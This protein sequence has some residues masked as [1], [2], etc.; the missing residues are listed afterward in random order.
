[1]KALIIA[2]KPSVARDIAAALGLGSAMENDNLVISHCIGHL[3]QLTYPLEQNQAL[4]I[5]PKSFELKVIDAVKDQFKKLAALIKRN[6]IATIINAC[7]AGREGEL[8]FRLVYDLVNIEK[9]IER[10]W[11]QSM[12]P[13]AIKIAYTGRKPGIQYQ[14]LYDAARSRSEA[15]WLYGINGSRAVKSAVG[16]V[17]TPTLAMVVDRY[18]IN[19]NFKPETFYEVVADFGVD[20]GTYQGK[21]NKDN[22]DIRFRSKEKAQEVIE[23]LK[24]ANPCKIEETKESKKKL[25]PLLFHLTGLQQEANRKF[26]YSAAD[27]LAITQ[28]LYEKHKVVTYPRTDSN[29]LPSDYL[30]TASQ[31]IENLSTVIPSASTVLE[32]NWIQLDKR[33]FNDAMI[34]DHFAI[35][36]TGKIPS[37]LTEPEKNIYDL[38]VKR[39]IAIFYPAAEY[40]HTIRLTQIGQAI[41]K[42]TGNVLTKPGWLSVYGSV[43]ESEESKDQLLTPVASGEQAQLLELSVKTGKTKPPALFNEATLLKAMETAGKEIDN[44][45]L[46]LAL[47]GKGIGTP[48]T[49]AAI[50]EKL[51]Q[52]TKAEPYLK[53]VKKS[54]VPT[55]RGLKLI[56]YLRQ[57]APTIISPELTGEWE[58][59][60]GMVERGQLTR[61]NFMLEINQAVYDLVSSLPQYSSPASVS[62]SL[63]QCPA[64]K[65]ADLVDRKFSYMCECGFKINKEISGYTLKDKDIEAIIQNGKTHKIQSFKSKAGK[66][67]AA[68]LAVDAEN[69][70]LVFN[71]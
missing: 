2:E 59:K 64:C 9:P 66:D 58:Y 38:I 23:R 37:A 57:A 35:V 3:V 62:K 71:F 6:D 18:E 13:E 1:M 25:P 55:E 28:S 17:M 45:E 11:L 10:M 32:N 7:D 24:T 49:R 19:T 16:R 27:T 60:L 68:V 42:T 20:S 67:F 29:A 65:Q 14:S 39:F 34:S 21:L 70:K 43:D 53:L 61:T 40:E 26:G 4:P 31:T 33:I 12:T 63:G 56:Q 41:F 69:K 54:L 15:D 48:A 8:I 22:N 5:L 44:E 51:K 36:P 46:A 52:A 47:K 30:D 50:I